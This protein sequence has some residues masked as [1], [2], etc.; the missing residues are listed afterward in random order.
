VHLAILIAVQ[1]SVLALLA[2]ET[3]R[4]GVHLSSP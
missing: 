3:W 4:E 1:S 2:A